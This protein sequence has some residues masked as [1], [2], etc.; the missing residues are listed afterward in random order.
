MTPLHETFC[1]DIK[2][3]AAFA[4]SLPEYIKWNL[5]RYKGLNGCSGFIL[6]VESQYSVYVGQA[7]YNWDGN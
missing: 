2:V 6:D 3:V 7:A 4:I 5:R 1:G